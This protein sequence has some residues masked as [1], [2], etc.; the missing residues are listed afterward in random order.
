MRLPSID[1]YIVGTKEMQ[2]LIA[3]QAFMDSSG[4]DET[5]CT[6]ELDGATGYGPFEFA[7]FG[8]YRPYGFA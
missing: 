2:E 1:P 8:P 5:L 3:L 7:C 6:F 4:L